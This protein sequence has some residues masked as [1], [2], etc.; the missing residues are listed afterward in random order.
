[1]KKI[2]SIVF[3]MCFAVLLNVSAFAYLYEYEGLYTVEIPEKFKQVEDDKFI[4]DDNSTFIISYEDNTELKYCVDDLN[5]KKLKEA[6]EFM[7]SEASN[8][9]Q[10]IGEEGKMELVSVKKIKH[11][12]GMSAT[13]T[14]YKT[15][16]I[17]NG[18]EKSHLQKVYEFGGAINK[19]T[20]VYTPYDDKNIDALD[21][22][23]DSIIINETEFPSVLDKM[24]CATVLIV[25]VVLLVVGIFKF[26]RK[27]SSKPKK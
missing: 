8:A 10:I 19:Y 5:E 27:P 13:V 26:L 20:F 7:A 12:N 24:G 11:P 21:E 15:S 3:F 1:M 16:A 17:M 4:S 9:F 2:L 23:F 6:A 22:T 14:V 18:E 25:I